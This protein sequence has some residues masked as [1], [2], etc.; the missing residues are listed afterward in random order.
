MASV[1]LAGPDV[2]LSEAI[3]MGRAKVALCAQLGLRGLYP[4]EA[5]LAVPDEARL[6]KRIFD[7][8]VSLIRGCDAVVANLTPFRGP[9]A[10]AGTVFE[11]G[12]ALALGKP[13]F[14]YSNHARHYVARV[15]ETHGPFAE[16]EG[17]FFARDGMSVENF[18]L[19]DNLMIDEAIRAQGW[20]IVAHEAEAHRRH[21]D[22]A[23]FEACLRQAAAYLRK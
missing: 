6:S 15:R 2:F 22:L 3:E 4:L 8:N 11:V 1:Y 23:G 9:S 17:Q 18:G 14:A 16:V 19:F 21:T 13:V 10:D 20:N 5:N 12:F 7:S